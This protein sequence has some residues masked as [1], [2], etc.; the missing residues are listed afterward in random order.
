MALAVVRF[1]PFGYAAAIW[2]VAV[3][4][5][6][7]PSKIK[8]RFRPVPGRLQRPI[9]SLTKRSLAPANTLREHVV[10]GIAQGILLFVVLVVV[11]LTASFVP[12]VQELILDRDRAALELQL[13]ALEQAGDWPAAA[14]LI[15]T[16]LNRRVSR[17]WG[18]ALHARLYNNLVQAGVA[19]KGGTAQSYFQRALEV[20]TRNGL[21]SELAATHLER[22]RLRGAIDQEKQA[23]AELAQRNNRQVGSST[24]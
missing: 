15:S 23:A 10:R 5:A 3:A 2:L 9:G 19:S 16:R 4:I 18:E 21:N 13:S 12:G 24:A 8:S 11:S 17:A 1:V 7:S 22:L 6:L 20:A 14:E